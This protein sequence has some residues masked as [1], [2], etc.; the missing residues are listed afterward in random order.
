[1][2]HPQHRVSPINI[3]ALP[4]Q[5]ALIDKAAALA[6]KSRSEFMLETA[7]RE[8]ENLLLDQRLF[9]ASEADYAKFSALL[10]SPIE[11]NLALKLLLDSKSPW[12]K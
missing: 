8:A 12:E 5:K 7:C 2:S 10:E 1:M 4:V 9:L 11:K 3:R 6:N